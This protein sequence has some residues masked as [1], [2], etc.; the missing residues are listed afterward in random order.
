MKLATIDQLVSKYPRLFHMAESG[1][2]ERIQENG[3]LSTTA[4]LDLFKVEEP[5]R[6]RIES[7]W[8]RESESIAPGVVIRDQKPMSP[9]SLEVVL[10][11]MTPE[12]WYRLLNHKTFFW[13]TLDRLK[14]MLNAGS[15]KNDHHDVLTVDTRKL[16]E[17][18]RDH[19]SLSR[20]NSGATFGYAK[21]GSGTFK[22]I[23]AYPAIRRKTDV[24]E[25]VVEYHV[26]HVVDFT[27]SVER[28]KGDDYL[29]TIWT[30]NGL[31]A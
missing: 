16:V 19:I 8:R 29:Q 15:Y 5:K 1:T 11:D 13:P 20:I 30:P 18:H 17:C 25:V 10:K 24:A 26:P 21:R 22:S 23:E 27:L 12:Q 6:S 2:W 4:L 7:E 14:K 31:D 9:R 3:L 28:W